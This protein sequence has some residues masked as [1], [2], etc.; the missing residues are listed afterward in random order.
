MKLLEK[1]QI[2]RTAVSD[3]FSTVSSSRPS[4]SRGSVVKPC[5]ARTILTLVLSIWSPNCCYCT[6]PEEHVFEPNKGRR[7]TGWNAFQ[8]LTGSRSVCEDTCPQCFSFSWEI[9]WCQFAKTWL[10]L[11]DHHSVS[12]LWSRATCAKNVILAVFVSQSFMW[13]RGDASRPRSV[14]HITH[15]H[16]TLSHF[17]STT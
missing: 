9:R 8:G 2:S 7:M 1:C 17:D 12:P 14:T 13:K 5:L 11:M 15:R 4:E 10:L 16:A 6:T 3:T